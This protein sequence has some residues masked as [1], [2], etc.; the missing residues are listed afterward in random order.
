MTT[1]WANVERISEVLHHLLAENPCGF[2][3]IRFPHLNGADSLSFKDYLISPS[4]FS[5]NLGAG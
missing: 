3:G 1:F 2:G 5:S 4:I